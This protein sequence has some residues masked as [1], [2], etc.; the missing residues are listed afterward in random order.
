MRASSLPEDLL[1]VR[2]VLVGN[3]VTSIDE[4]AT[5]LTSET[6]PFVAARLA[7]WRKDSAGHTHEYGES[8][9]T[10]LETFYAVVA[11]LFA[12]GSLGCVR[13]VANSR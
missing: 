9:Y 12:N 7:A 8:A 6:K 11:R 10:A 4:F 3:T 1:D 2:T 5:D 13:L